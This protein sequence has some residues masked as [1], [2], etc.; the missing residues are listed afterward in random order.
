MASRQTPDFAFDADPASGVNVYNGYNGGWF[1]VGGTS[2]A[3]PSLAGIVN[4]ANN[5][6]GSYF[7]PPVNPAG[8]YTNEENNLLYAQLPARIGTVNFYD[9]KT[10]SNGCTVR[11]NW[12]YCTGV[13]SPRGLLGK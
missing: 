9:V 7:L 11:A 5:R 10:G 6:L 3:S 13:G 4:L 12:D 1:V 8:Y 2:V